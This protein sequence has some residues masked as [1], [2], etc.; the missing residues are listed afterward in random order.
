MVKQL[1]NSLYWFADSQFAAMGIDSRQTPSA[2]PKSTTSISSLSQKAWKTSL[3]M[4]ILVASH[5]ANTI[6]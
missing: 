4:V 3:Q 5:A 6:S 1:V 2:C